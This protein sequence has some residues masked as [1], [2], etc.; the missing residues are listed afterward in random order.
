MY[1]TNNTIAV[2]DGVFDNRSA[3][4]KRET[5]GLKEQILSNSSYPSQEQNVL[6][7][8]LLL[9]W[10]KID[11]SEAYHEEDDI[12]SMRSPAIAMFS[13]TESCLISPN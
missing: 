5:W 3:G 7:A 13:I 1:L 10:L 2:D 11:R 9:A 8:N 6:E 4:I 12:Y